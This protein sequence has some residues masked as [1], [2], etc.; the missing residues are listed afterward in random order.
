MKKNEHITET[1]PD[2]KR[3]NV[4]LMHIPKTSGT[5]F[6]MKFK[7]KFKFSDI[8]PGNNE[9][10]FNHKKFTRNGYPIITFL[11]NP[12]KHVVSQYIFCRY[13]KWGKR[14]SKKLWKQGKVREDM[15]E[16]FEDWLK[17]T[18]TPIGKSTKCYYPFNM[19]TR[20][21]TCDDMGHYYIHA[22]QYNVEKAFYNLKQ[23]HFGLTEYFRE[24]VCLILY[25][26]GKQLPVSCRYEF[27]H[28]FNDVKERHGAPSYNTTMFNVDLDLIEFD[29]KLYKLAVNEFESRLNKMEHDV[30]YRVADSSISAANLRL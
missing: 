15:E 12:V 25:E 20:F 16:G 30:G 9:R 14:V 27:R 1:E 10:C 13:S 28:L 4:N 17:L 7:N 22:H 18:H 29:M 8:S 19:Q 3:L 5:S 26:L 23:T 2:F 24:S 21:L 6:Y 11:R